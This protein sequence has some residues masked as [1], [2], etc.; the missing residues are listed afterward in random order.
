MEYDN[1]L[2]ISNLVIVLFHLGLRKLPSLS[3]ENNL[4][5][6]AQSCLLQVV[7]NIL[8]THTIHKEYFLL[9]LATLLGVSKT[10]HSAGYM[11]LLV[12]CYDNKMVKSPLILIIL[13]LI[14]PQV[15][16]QQKKRILLTILSWKTKILRTNKSGTGCFYIPLLKVLRGL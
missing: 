4:G 5:F 8:N 9:R 2:D 16:N 1:L 7:K 12:K 14:K 3:E 11:L 6:E 15:A 13:Y 10:R